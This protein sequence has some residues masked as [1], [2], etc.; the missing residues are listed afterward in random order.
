[1]NNDSDLIDLNNLNQCESLIEQI[2]FVNLNKRDLFKM[3]RFCRFKNAFKHLDEWRFYK[4]RNGP[5]GLILIPN[6]FKDD[7]SVELFNQLL[8]EIPNK[9]YSQLKSNLIK[10]PI[11]Q[12]NLLESK[13]R[14][15]TFGH[16]YDWTNKIYFRNDFN[17][18]PSLLDD[19]LSYLKELL[20]LDLKLEA[21]IVNY[22]TW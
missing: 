4:I 21:G 22:Y 2:D 19:L 15:I 6:V 18:M 5:D 3:E 20:N 14:W 16:H 11:D 8:Y 13:L 17:K 10:L 1:M 7:F 9:Y 12:D